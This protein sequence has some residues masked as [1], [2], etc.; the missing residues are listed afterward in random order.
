MQRQQGHGLANVQSFPRHLIVRN[1]VLEKT[2]RGQ[3]REPREL[4][5]SFADGADSGV[6]RRHALERRA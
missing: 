5:V 6:R 2:C 3:Y 1:V 4:G